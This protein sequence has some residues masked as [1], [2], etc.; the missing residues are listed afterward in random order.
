[1]RKDASTI[2]GRRARRLAFSLAALLALGTP[3]AAAATYVAHRELLSGINDGSVDIEIVT[4]GTLGLLTHA[5][6]LDW[7]ITMFDG[8]S[9]FTLTGPLS[10]N[11]SIYEDHASGLLAI[12]DRLKLTSDYIGFFAPGRGP[13]G[14]TP[15]YC[16]GEVCEPTFSDVEV[17]Y[18]FGSALGAGRL[19]PPEDGYV[20][21]RLASVVVPNPVPEPATWALLI[22]GFGMAGVGLR[23]QRRRIAVRVD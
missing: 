16:Y 2:A 6:I 15:V 17:V 20:V 7:R 21:A 13:G 18:G 8:F 23:S 9:T 22:L 1:M 4:D 19:V 12:D 10:G 14:S 3:P 5:N 11:N